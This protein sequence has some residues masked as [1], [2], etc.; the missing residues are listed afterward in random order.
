MREIKFRGKRVDNGEWA[1]GWYYQNADMGWHFI[2]EYNPHGEDALTM[3]RPETIG[4]FTGIKDTS[5]KE[6]FEGDIIVLVNKEEWENRD[7]DHMQ[8]T[9]E[10][11]YHVYEQGFL[12]RNQERLSATLAWGGTK[13][14]TVIGN[15]HDNY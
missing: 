11:Y 15:I 12:G 8:G 6:V 4:Q 7:A 13:S 14:R 9:Y 1:Y 3:V 10:V 2:V 5:G